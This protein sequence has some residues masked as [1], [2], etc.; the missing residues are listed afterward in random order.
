MKPCAYRKNHEWE[1]DGPGQFWLCI[2]CYARTGDPEKPRAVVDVVQPDSE[3][4][5]PVEPMP[6][7][8]KQLEARGEYR[9][10]SKGWVWR[11]R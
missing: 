8:A 9:Y 6:T 1:W 11:F 4:P 2:H 7:L 3:K 10:T 5:T